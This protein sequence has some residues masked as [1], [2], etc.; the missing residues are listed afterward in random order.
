MSEPKET[1]SLSASQPYDFAQRLSDLCSAWDSQARQGKSEADEAWQNAEARVAELQKDVANACEAFDI[2]CRRLDAI[3]KIL[4]ETGYASEQIG[5]IS[6]VI[7]GD[8]ERFAS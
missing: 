3:E 4:G 7:K 5:R 8:P 1:A 6:D 2:Q